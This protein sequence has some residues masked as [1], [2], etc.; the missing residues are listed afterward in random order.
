MF[1]HILADT[2][3]SVGVI[4]STI[5]IQ[6][7]GWTGFDPIASLFIAILI[8]LSVIPLVRQS[9]SVLMLELEDNVVSQV[10]GALDELAT[11]D[12][13]AAVNQPRFWPNEA[14][15]LVGS[16]HIQAKDG[17]DIQDLRRRVS[18][19]LMSHIDGLKEVCVQ[20]EYE[21][22]AKARLRT[23][24]HQQSPGFFYRSNSPF[25]TAVSTTAIHQGAAVS[26]RSMLPPQPTVALA[27]ANAEY[28]SNPTQ[29]PLASQAPPTS[30]LPGTPTITGLTKKQTKKE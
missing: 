27:T 25:Q 30:S 12:S 28:A 1:L 21:S 11:M 3:G 29:S 2:L 17:A 14:E 22:A 9:A 19:L 24:V 5:L 23:T 13:V 18:E 15:T 4:V 7:L 10:Q 26:H 20:V 6:W 16:V 8:V